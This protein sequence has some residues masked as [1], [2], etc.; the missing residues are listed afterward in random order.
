MLGGTALRHCFLTCLSLS[1]LTAAEHHGQ[2]AFGGLPLPGA[3]V[4]AIQGGRNF[5]A[6][7]DQQGLY[8][9]PDLPDGVWTIRVEM[10]L[11][12]TIQRDVTIAPGAP[13]A[14]WEMMLLPPD[15]IKATPM[16]S[17]PAVPP[18][19]PPPSASSAPQGK[20]AASP[21]QAPAPAPPPAADS[22][23]ESAN[24]LSQRA[25]DGFLVNGSVNNSAASPFAQL[26]TFGNNRTAGQGLYNG[27]LGMIFDNS[28][29]DAQSYSVTGQDTPKPGY[30]RVTA[31][32]TLGGPLKIPH[33]L[34][35]GP[36]FFISYQLLRNNT[37]TTTPALVPTA[38][39][40][41]S[42]GEI[43]PQAQA[44]L[45]F[46]P[47][48]NFAGGTRYNYQSPL[49]NI[50]HQ[51]SLQS[52]LTKALGQRDFLFGGFAFQRT[53]SSAQNTFGFVDSTNI[54]GIN[55][56]ANWNHRFGHRLLV[57][58]KIVYSL[59]S[60]RVT[61]YFANREDVS[62]EASITGN[63]Q[64]PINW[65]P[66]TLV[67]SSGI[68]TLS[69]GTASFNRNQTAQF[70]WDTAWNRA[71]HNIAF[72]AD[73]RRQQFNYLAQTN[74]R[75]TFLFTGA[76][77]GSDFGDFLAGIPDVSNIAFG[78][79]DKYFRQS[80]WDAFINDDFRI[81]PNLTL[82]AGLRWEYEQPITEKYGRL[83]NLDIAPGFTAATPV[84]AGETSSPLIHPDR[85]GVQPRLGLAWR[86]FSGSST[87]IRAGYGVYFNTSVYQSIA[88]LLAQQYPLS[89]SLS[90]QNSPADPL[91]LASGFNV[92]PAVTQTTFAIDPDFR[93]GYAQN[94]QA[95]IQR[96]LPGS[97]VVTATY[98]GIKGTRGMQEFAP[99]TYPAGAVNPCPSCP[100]GFIYLAS[101]GDSTRES[102]QFQL[103]RRL[104]NG[105]T[106]SV[107]YTYSK[108]IDDSALG[109]RN[110]GSQVIAENWLDLSAERALSNFDQRQL[111]NVQMQYTTGMGIGGGALLSGWKGTWFKEWTF[112]TQITAGTGL[113]LTP[114]VILPAGITGI[115]GS[116]RPDYTGASVYAAPPGLFLNPG[117]YTLAA[118]GQWGNAGRNSIE[119]PDQFSLNARM[120][121]TFRLRDRLSL[122][123]QVAATNALN[124]VVFPNWNTVVGSPELGLP[125]T[126][127]PMRSL[128]TTLRLRF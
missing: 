127:N 52:R 104:H 8:S 64:D 40:R 60:T 121:R 29:L 101:N 57:H 100:A 123:A 124:H 125:T 39:Q 93:I 50:T 85:R 83:V 95:S 56:N 11:F 96:N 33:L 102:G 26:P 76:A 63:N 53:A 59:L 122:D 109:G 37:T 94:W 41:S 51:D 58:F 128:Q 48:P 19:A 88:P 27:S 42:A 106:A 21:G 118:P 84:V 86:P 44:L 67:F 71:R 117:A 113:P 87:V 72:G 18:P 105:F 89:K 110:Q 98:L 126:A 31:L 62:G 65:G 116:L 82:N 43:S 79:A 97:L 34:K 46:Y 16:A 112:A 75:G 2:V 28:A 91:T 22:N 107:Q 47:L 38:D 36:V 90:V 23:S 69:D 78:N 61:P 114:S 13:G 81:S 74:P 92:S 70:S 32:A 111:L 99:N 30:N 68:A 120:S 4:T 55:T 54:F 9:F 115:T 119:G 7:T 66:P 15:Q 10:L 80:V 45:A 77:T 14:E 25:T 20:A 35:N 73:F 1:A 24:E 3:T 103:R 108:S 5:T 6:V 17:A 12:A 49:V